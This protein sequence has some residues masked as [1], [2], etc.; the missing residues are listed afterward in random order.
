MPV[1]TGALE[2]QNETKRSEAVRVCIEENHCFTPL[3]SLQAK[4][5]F[6]IQKGM[7]TR[8]KTNRSRNFETKQLKQNVISKL[9]SP[10]TGKSKSQK[11]ER[12]KQI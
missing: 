3:L 10:K 8:N 9:P 2:L 12:R 4:A 5:A 1:G 11:Q 7:W 6:F